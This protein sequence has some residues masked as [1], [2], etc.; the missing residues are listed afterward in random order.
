MKRTYLILAAACLVL[1]NTACSSSTTE[2]TAAG[3]AAETTVQETKEEETKE[4]ESKETAKKETESKPEET[5][6]ETEEEI[7][8]KM[9][10]GRVTSVKKT[11]VT[12]D[13]QDDLTYQV[14]LKDAETRSEL[15]VGEG[16][17]IQVVF[18][19]DEEEIKKAESYDIITSAAMVGDMDPVI[20]GVVQSSGADFIA[21]EAASGKSY[22][23]STVIAQ[24]VAGDKG[25]A[26]GEYAEI[27]YL[28]KPSDGKALRIIMEEASGDAEATFY[29]MKG[30]MAAADDA[31]VTIEAAD[32]SRFKFSAGTDVFPTDYEI[33]E[34]IEVFYEGSLTAG[35]AVAQVIDYP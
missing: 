32:G 13:G 15:E 31:S 21:I 5:T 14:E 16:D 27:T 6:K 18:L 11:I 17:E 29:V 12:I 3:T 34:E 1:G 28:G 24:V 30:N 35:N 9:V 26:V 23:F 2:T 8:T 19:E 20:A 4:Q 25:L 33:G 7:E 10:T 22:R